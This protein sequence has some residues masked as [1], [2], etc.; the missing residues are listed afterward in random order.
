[1]RCIVGSAATRVVK[2]SFGWQDMRFSRMILL[3]G[4]LLLHMGI[5]RRIITFHVS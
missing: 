1:M 4:S 2:E 5:S 3:R